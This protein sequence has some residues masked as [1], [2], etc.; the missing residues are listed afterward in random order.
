M[1]RGLIFALVFCASLFVL[2]SLG[3][4]QAPSLYLI[5]GQGVAL[6]GGEI[7]EVY[8]GEKVFSGSVRLVPVDNAAAHVAFLSKVIGMTASKYE[9]IWTKKAFRDALNPPTVLSTDTQVI[10]FVKRTVGAVGYVSTPPTGVT[11]IRA[12]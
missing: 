5:G 8:L 4:A 3:Q 9:S 10:D 2:G 1:K 7:K 12:F 6:S 11:V